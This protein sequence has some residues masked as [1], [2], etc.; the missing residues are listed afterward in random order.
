PAIFVP[1]FPFV[2]APGADAIL[3]SSDGA[4]FYVHRH[5][6]A[7]VSPIFRDMFTLPQPESTA[8]IPSI[9]LQED[10]VVLDRALRFFYRNLSRGTSAAHWDR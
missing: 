9:P 3:Q 5:I 4:D 7:L 10:S 6:L 1:A 2:N 8:A